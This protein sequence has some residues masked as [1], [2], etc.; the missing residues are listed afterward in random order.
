MR[1]AAAR[2]AFERLAVGAFGDYGVAEGQ[3]RR[4]PAFDHRARIRR[5]LGIDQRSLHIR[6]GPEQLACLPTVA[7]SSFDRRLELYL[8]G[9]K[10]SHRPG[11]HPQL[12]LEVTM[13][14]ARFVGPGLRCQSKTDG[15]TSPRLL[16]RPV[17]DGDRRAIED[18]IPSVE[19]HQ[20]LNQAEE[21]LAVC[22]PLSIARARAGLR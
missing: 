6:R 22:R 15:P 16:F 17:V 10:W 13:R 1:T 3:C 7:V 4:G 9:G 18:E 19:A 12:F 21:A 11:H 14:G 8:R 20:G 5:R 2:L